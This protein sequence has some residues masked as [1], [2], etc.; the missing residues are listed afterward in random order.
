MYQSLA[1]EVKGQIN[2][3]S[4]NC[5]DHRAVCKQH[6][7]QGY[8]TVK[9]LQGGKR[10]TSLQYDGS[11]S[12]A[13][14][15]KFLDE[16]VNSNTMTRIDAERFNTTVAEND[17]F[18]VFLQSFVTTKEQVRSV[19]DAVASL[20]ANVRVFTSNDPALYRQLS[21]GH[22]YPDSALLAFAG[23]SRKPVASMPLPTNQDK[24]DRFV[25][26]N[27]FPLT[28]DVSESMYLDVLKN[29]EFRPIVVMVAVKQDATKSESE[30]ELLKIARAWRKMP[31]TFDQPVWFASVNGDKWAKWLKRNYGMTPENMPAVVILDSKKDEYY[32]TTLEGERVKLEGASIFSVL[33]GVYQ[34]FLVPKKPESRFAWGTEGMRATFLE[35]VMWMAENPIKAF[36]LSLFVLMGSMSLAGRCFQR[37]RGGLGGYLNEKGYRRGSNHER[38]D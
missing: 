4:V 32:D 2:V 37:D 8:P 12:I 25:F 16:N 35:V 5:D 29:K 23:H 22:P 34:K 3:A 28:Y 30:A 18:F 26:D 20:P 7:I 9:L 19:K 15:R 24:L 27:Q 11:R 1:A 33:E 36:F 6:D 13:K 14:I 17:V 10:G 38:L 31:R 21:V